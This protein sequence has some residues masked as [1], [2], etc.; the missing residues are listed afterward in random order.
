MSRLRRLSSVKVFVLILVI[1]LTSVAHADYDEP[2]VEAEKAE[3]SFVTQERWAWQR[4]GSFHA[5]DFPTATVGWLGGELLVRGY[6]GPGGAWSWVQVAPQ[7]TDRRSIKALDF[8]SSRYGCALGSD[9]TFL[10]TG[11][12]GYV[13]QVRSL[14]SGVSELSAVHMTGPEDIYAVGRNTDLNP[15]GI[16]LHSDDAGV[17]WDTLHTTPN[18]AYLNDLIFY[19]DGRGLVI[20]HDWTQIAGYTGFVLKI[21]D[22]AVAEPY[23]KHR[24][25]LRDLSAPTEEYIY[26][27]GE[28]D[29]MGEPGEGA[30][31]YSHTGGASWNYVVL[32]SDDGLIEPWSIYFGNSTEGWVGASSRTEEALLFK[33]T[34]R[35]ATWEPQ[36]GFPDIGQRLNSLDLI[37]GPDTTSLF[38]IQSTKDGFFP[39]NYGCPGVVVQSTN[40]GVSW[41]RLEVLSGFWA[42]QLA[43]A[44]SY[45][46]YEGLLL[47]RLGYGDSPSPAGLRLQS[48]SSSSPYTMPANVETD[49]V[50][51]RGLDLVGED[52]GWA[53]ADHEGA[54]GKIWRSVDLD[55]AWDHQT[56]PA[57][58]LAG[59]LSAYNALHAWA[60]DYQYRFGYNPDYVSRLVTTADGATWDETPVLVSNY[61]LDPKPDARVSMANQDHGCVLDTPF[62]RTH[63]TSDGWDTYA[64]SILYCSGLDV[65]MWDTS[66]G[67]ILCYDY[68]EDVFEVW[69]TTDGGATWT[70]TGDFDP[71]DVSEEEDQY[72]SY[73]YGSAL[74]F[75]S[76][77][78]GWFA[79]HNIWETTNGGGTWER[80]F[81]GI[82]PD[83]GMSLLDA[84]PNGIAWAASPSGTMLRWEPLVLG[85]PVST[86]GGQLPSPDDGRFLVEFPAGAVPTETTASLG[87]YEAG[88]TGDYFAQRI[89]ELT[90]DPDVGLSGPITLTM[91]LTP[92][93]TAAGGAG[94]APATVLGH[95]ESGAWVPLADSHVGPDGY[96]TGTTEETGFFAVMSPAQPVYL[97]AIFRGV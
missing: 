65:A 9:D 59:D 36:A 87:A 73:G 44:P 75:R 6:Q 66:R 86:S 47:G 23:T 19:P 22:G 31:I 83:L 60:I 28:Y 52:S 46:V 72:A 15:R 33:S 96:L 51:W 42:Q 53:T 18:T 50:E 85:V 41:Q 8:Y 34:D 74:S 81:D 10:Y 63:C 55:H 12:S 97:P 7:L 76:S 27:T 30:V 11:E 89:Y 77:G 35:G 14:P 49:F 4:G 25:F 93:V 70:P 38:A 82:H 37:G 43:L 40:A 67:W 88:A 21:D 80:S 58:S 29:P 57:S 16:V 45:T 2:L 69:S 94:D 68:G 84:N 3:T 13:W 20:G 78:T 26:A 71:S 5:V 79:H 62:A 90:L 32:P 48:V 92:T 64:S 17:S 95:W 24:L 61:P 54:G 91:I 39:C 56:A 1:V